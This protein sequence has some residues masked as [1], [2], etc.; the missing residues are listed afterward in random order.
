MGAMS[1]DHGRNLGVLTSGGDAP[2]MNAA[3][4]AVVRTALARGID[5]FAIH[6]GLQGLVEGG[7][8][9]RRMDWDSVGGILHQGGTVIGSARSQEFREREGRRASK[10][11]EMTFVRRSVS[12]SAYRSMC[13]RSMAENPSR[14]FRFGPEWL[15][16]L[17]SMKRSARSGIWACMR[18]CTS[19]RMSAGTAPQSTVSSTAGPSPSSSPIT[20]A[21]AR[22]RPAIPSDSVL[23][24]A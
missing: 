6:E 23:R 10:A 19:A 2:G 18:R 13:W 1:N 22:S 5:V 24:D 8:K 9:I 14:V 15:C 7:D 21:L 4:R 16:E 17:Q 11:A 3:V 20:S 12:C